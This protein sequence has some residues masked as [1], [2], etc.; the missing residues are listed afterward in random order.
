LTNEIFSKLLTSFSI[1]VAINVICAFVTLP[2]VLGVEIPTNGTLCYI[3]IIHQITGEKLLSYTDLLINSGKWNFIKIE[4]SSS[5][6][7]QNI[8]IELVVRSLKDGNIINLEYM[9][10]LEHPS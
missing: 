6:F 5:L 8:S 10:I 2:T 1:W 4:A 3:N 9:L 7:H